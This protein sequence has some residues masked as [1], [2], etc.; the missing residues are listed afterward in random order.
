MQITD[1][2]NAPHYLWQ[3]DCDGWRLC[4]HAEL[5]VTLERMPA[6]REEIGHHH[7]RARQVFCCQAGRLEIV[8]PEEVLSLSPGQSVT[9]PPGLWHQA[10]APEDCEFLVI[11]TPSTRGDRIEGPMPAPATE[12]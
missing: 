1:R 7:D 6:G 10:R 5:G 12:V 2:T 9:I 11:A 4:D 8:T 3:G